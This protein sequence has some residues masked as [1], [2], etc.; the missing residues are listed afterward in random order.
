MPI[1]YPVRRYHEYQRSL[2]GLISYLVTSG[3]VEGE[4]GTALKNENDALPNLAWRKF[5]N[6][7]NVEVAK[8]SK[9]IFC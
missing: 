1:I 4:V 2:C 5:L 8:S 7:E 3:R 9:L 6:T